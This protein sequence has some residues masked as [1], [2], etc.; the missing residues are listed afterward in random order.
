MDS[1]TLKI[2]VAGNVF[3]LACRRRERFCVGSAPDCKLSLD[4]RGVAEEHCEIERTGPNEFRVTPLHGNPVE[5]NGE[6]TGDEAVES[7]FR[8][9]IA[10]HLLEIEMVPDEDAIL[11]EDPVEDVTAPTGDAS[12][13]PASPATF[14]ANLLP[15]PPRKEVSFPRMRSARRAAIPAIRFGAVYPERIDVTGRERGWRSQGP[16]REVPVAVPS[17]I[18]IPPRGKGGRLVERAL[19]ASKDEAPPRM[20]PGGFVMGLFL[21]LALFVT[22]G[23]GWFA[24]RKF[25]LPKS[26]ELLSEKIRRGD[27]AAEATLALSHLRGEWGAEFDFSKGLSM[28]ESAVAK[29]DPCGLLLAGLLCE[30]GF[31]LKGVDDLP[32]PAARRF[33]SRALE[34]GAS[35]RVTDLG[36]PRWDALLAY[37]EFRVNGSLSADSRRLLD[38]SFDAEYPTAPFVRIAIPGEPLSREEL[39]KRADEF[40]RKELRRGSVHSATLLGLLH[41]SE[42]FAG[43]DRRYGLDRLREAADAGEPKAAARLAIL[44]AE[45][46]E[47]DDAFRRVSM[48]L[49]SGLTEA[50]AVAGRFYL[51]GVGTVP[52]PAKGFELA[53]E[54]ATL[55]SVS[56]MA[57]VARAYADGEG[58]ASNP[59]EAIRI[60]RNLIERGRVR[61][62]ADLGGILAKLGRNS[63]AIEPLRA[64]ALVGEMESAF[65]LGKVLADVG[66]S[67]PKAHAEAVTWFEK[68]MDAGHP[69]AALE[70]ARIIDDPKRE[71]RDPARAVSVLRSLADGGDHAAAVRLANYHR[72]GRGVERDPSKALLLLKRAADAGERSAFFPLAQMYETGT[73]SLTPSP[74]TAFLY[75]RKAFEAADERIGERFPGLELG[76]G[77]VEDYVLSWAGDDHRATLAWVGQRVTNYFSLSEPGTVAVAALEQGFRQAWPRREVELS[78]DPVAV[79]LVSMEQIEFRL[80]YRILLSREGRRVEAEAVATVSLDFTHPDEVPRVVGVREKVKRWRLDPSNAHFERGQDSTTREIL[81]AVPVTES[82]VDIANLPQRAVESAKSIPFEDRF[83]GSFAMV[84]VIAGDGIVSFARLEGGGELLVPETY[85]DETVLTRIRQFAE[86]QSFAEFQ[87]WRGGLILEPDRADP[88][89][90]ELLRRAENGDHEAEAL[91]GEA[92][93]DGLGTFPKNRVEA[94][95]WFARSARMEHLL[96]QVWIA[97]MVRDGEFKADAPARDLFLNLVFRMSEAINL[98]STKAVYLRA[99]AECHAGAYG[100]N[101]MDN[102]LAKGLLEQA[103]VGGDPRAK[104]LLGRDYLKR[105]PTLAV[106][107]LRVAADNRCASAATELSKYYLGAGIE[108]PLAVNLLKLAANKGDI[109]AQML[110]GQLLASEEGSELEAAFWLELALRNALAAND[111]ANEARIRA[112]IRKQG[113]RISEDSFRRSRSFLDKTPS[114]LEG[115]P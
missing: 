26:P 7:P 74:A 75:Y 58:V 52:D 35:E 110:L 17:T 33:W 97:I 87:V 4:G 59:G 11:L 13:I 48:A 115:R 53:H 50:K 86:G 3:F 101:P 25:V 62:N 16:L 106:G 76:L 66:A 99:A 65:L 103:A 107:P 112:D 109:E 34:S 114:T 40:A 105:S 60:W 41:T 98:S 54:A 63:E 70:L 80:P 22:G 20:V 10:R 88:A 84:P 57:T 30:E 45:E 47:G 100:E 29:G 9:K 96:G 91:V 28:T 108:I 69:G 83:G 21:V 15:L 31:P 104:L 38:R 67:D 43:A 14:P 113:G 102:R 77:A 1:T 23:F 82:E 6:P 94:G 18:A 61:Y 92:Y 51:E 73:S 39:L 85:F 8:L 27:T 81:P 2:E 79:A 111:K 68:S 72:D 32:G 71:H 89:T 93:Y 24:W 42:E 36:D 55:G 49:G 64:S 12:A 5:V 95:K 78:G 46:G 37:A 19:K 90:A 56:G 44:L